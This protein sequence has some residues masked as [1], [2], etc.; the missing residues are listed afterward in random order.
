METDDGRLRNVIDV[1]T[2]VAEKMKGISEAEQVAVVKGLGGTYHQTRLQ[3]LLNDLGSVDS[4]Y[5]KIYDSSVNSA[6]SAERE[7]EKFMKS[8]QARINLARVEVEKLALAMGDAFLTESMITGI[9]LFGDF[10]GTITK[11]VDKFGVLPA[12]LGT[13]GVAVFLL[14]SRFR[15]LSGAVGT[16]VTSL[17]G[18]RGAATASATASSLASGAVRGLSV[19]FKGL[20]ASTG[21]GLAL[22]GVGVVIEGLLGH[23]TKQREL[24]EEIAQSN[25]QLVDSY[26]ANR[27]TIQDLTVEYAKLEGAMNKSEPSTETQKR[28]YDVQ[29]QIAELMPNLVRYEDSYGNKIIDTSTNINS[30]IGML[31]KQ[32]EVQERLQKIQQEAADEELLRENER[33]AKDK[34]SKAE[35][36]LKYFNEKANGSFMGADMYAYNPEGGIKNLQDMEAAIKHFEEQ[37]VYYAE[38]GQKGI[39][40]KMSKIADTLQKEMNTYE[41]FIAEADTAQFYVAQKAI[42]SAETVISESTAI[43]DVTKE[44]AKNMLNDFSVMAESSTEAESIANVFGDGSFQKTLTEASNHIKRFTSSTSEEFKSQKAELLEYADVLKEALTSNMKDSKGNAI[45]ENSEEFKNAEKS[46]QSYI[47]KVI[48]SEQAVRDYADANGVS[49]DAARNATAMLDEQGGAFEDA[50]DKVAEYVDKLREKN[51]VEEQM[52]GVSQNQINAVDD[53]IYMYEALSTQTNLTANQT[54]LL[55]DAEE[56]LK[57]LYPELSKFGLLRI[58][59]I[60]KEKEAQ[61]ILL[62]SVKLSKEGKLKAEEDMTLSSALGTKARIDNIK[63]ELEAMLTLFNSYMAEAQRLADSSKDISGDMDAEEAYIKALK[64]RNFEMNKTPY[65]TKAAE[66]DGYIAE[67][68]TSTGILKSSTGYQEAYNKSTDKSTKS[69]KD[70]TKA[71]ENSIYVTDQYK[72]SLEAVNLEQEKQQKLRSGM[73]DF[74]KQYRDSLQQE[75]NLEKQKTK[76]MQDQAASIEKQI[77]SGKINQTGIVTTSSG[78]TTTSS[79]GSKSYSGKYSSEI[80]SAASKYGVDPNLIAAIIKQESGFNA[81][82]VSSAGARGLMQLMPGTASGL[83]VKD[84]FNAAQ[85]IMGGTKYIADQLKAFGG[86]LEKALAAYN[87]GP[88]NVRKYG[89]IPPFKE[90]QNYVKKVSANYASYSGGSGTTTTTDTSNASKEVAQAQQAIDQAKSDLLGLQSSILQSQE[91]IAKLE[92]E[93]INSQISEFDNT[94]KLYQ[95][96]LDYESAKQEAISKTGKEYRASID[97]QITAMNGQQSANQKEIKYLEDL[98]ANGKLSALAMNEMK[99]KVKALKTEMLQL[100]TAIEDANFEKITSRMAAFDESQDDLQYLV[101]LTGEYMNSLTEGSE[102]YN[103]AAKDQI[104]TMQKQQRMIRTQIDEHKNDLATKKLGVQATKDLKE[105]IEDLTIAYYSLGNGIK[106]ST[107][108]LK[109]ANERMANEVADKLI[110]SYKNYTEERKNA[111]MKTLDAEMKAEEKRHKQ[112]SDNLS[113]ELEAYKKIIQAKLDMLDKEESE[114]DYNKEID[115]L[116]KERLEIL[117]KINLL[118]LDDSFE[119]RKETANLTEKLNATEEQIAEKRHDRE[120]ELRKE[121]LNDLLDKKEEEVKNRQDLE[122]ERYE[123]E[124]ELIDKQKEDWEQYYNNLLND[125]RKFAKLR[126]DIVA[127][128]TDAIKAEFGEILDY[129][130]ETM[131][132]LENT[133]DGTMQAVGTSIR[134]NMIDNLKEA[135]DL[136][137]QLGKNTASSP[138]LGNQF[139]SDKTNTTPSKPASPTTPSAGGQKGNGTI[140]IVKPINL[141]KRQRGSDEM[142]FERI[143]KPGEKYPV[144]GEETR[145]NSFGKQYDVGGG[146]WITDMPGYIKYAKFEKGGFTGNQQGWSMLHPEEFVLNKGMTKEALKMADLFANLN[147]LINPIRMQ[148]IKQPQLASNSNNISSTPIHFYVDKMYANEKEVD[149]FGK[150]L[151]EKMNRFKG[152]W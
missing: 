89:G 79:T 87:A 119:A 5:R 26:T 147:R 112:V 2:E 22:V 94:R 54:F 1:Y 138:S 62:N 120:I 58:D 68:N 17:L 71:T 99:E 31:E 90:T 48:L 73:T 37:R 124:K 65:K 53:L 35:T 83:G 38:Q 7:N 13:T 113:K 11:F 24:Q 92:L 106:S 150:R 78:S 144:Y 70:S 3:V 127:G 60:K 44:L 86:N 43:S 97:K 77:K 32:I 45:S 111:H 10:L 143:L 142:K 91:T 100:G 96:T 33:L 149:D 14:S 135:I 104:A 82:A 108:S 4:M 114:R 57:A 30:K 109:E 67:L 46:I 137:S 42:E 25:R 41:R 105:K 133:L 15:T 51:S 152:G 101:D 52:V 39:S 18:F 27:Q 139:E 102:E 131:P 126:E 81:K 23:M 34:S 56:K 69:T 29:N 145:A 125:E 49:I 132:D 19:A 28:Y 130:K 61:E 63:K 146:M 136:M 129:F 128:N 88:G 76:L 47:D 148:P 122:D 115:T 16:S 66:L 80:N 8:L 121:N 116:E 140:E 93:I 72:K 117:D 141:W 36:Q 6:G 110:D 107:E 59:S 85:N 75:I 123:H 55:K 21:V 134:Q 84:S 103:K 12:L 95:H 74:S 64:A 151:E 98:I 9:E 40:A 50:G 20:L 118:S